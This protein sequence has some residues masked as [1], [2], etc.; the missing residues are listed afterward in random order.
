M[1]RVVVTGMGIVSSIGNNAEEVTQSCA[2]RNPASSRRKITSGW[3]SAPRCM[4]L[5]RSISR[6]DRPPRP[7]LSGRWR[8]LIWVAMNQAI[9][10]AGL[11]GK[12]YLQSAH[13][14]R[15]WARAGPRPRR[16]SR[17][18][19]SR[20]TKGPKR[21]GPFAVPKA[22]SSTCSANSFHLVQDQ[23][24]ELFHLLGLLD[25]GQL[26]RQCRRDD[27]MGQAGHD[28]RR[29]RRGTG[30]DAQRIVRRH[31]RD[32]VEIQRHAAKRPP[33]PMTRTAT[34]S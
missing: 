10:D 22:M 34:A 19:T 32:V 27:P 17:P 7:A 18:P 31:G 24:R 12:R 9:A 26:H 29:R 21:V 20:A 25:L 14:A 2:R 13:R 28:V 6:R 15:S 8:R 30:L 33:A 1:R 16:S 5:S 4:A 3:A 23:G 11:D